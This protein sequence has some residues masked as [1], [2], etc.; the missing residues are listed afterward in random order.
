MNP[1]TNLQ[2]QI[3]QNKQ[4]QYFIEVFNCCWVEV[5]LIILHAVPN[6]RK[7]CRYDMQNRNSSLQ[8]WYMIVI[9]VPSTHFGPEIFHFSRM[10]AQYTQTMQAPF[11]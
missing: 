10:V 5:N 2:S 4:L 7:R 9:D 1:R 8:K 6:L 3:L 11:Y